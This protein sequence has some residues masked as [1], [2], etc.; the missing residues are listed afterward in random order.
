MKP[1]R[2]NRHSLNLHISTSEY[3]WLKGFSR[4]EGMS[5]ADIIRDQIRASML[6]ELALVAIEARIRCAWAWCYSPPQ[7]AGENV[8]RPELCVGHEALAAKIL[9]ESKKAARE[10]RFRAER[11]FEE[12]VRAEDLARRKRLDLRRGRRAK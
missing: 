11:A 5:M 10:M 4:H 1:S 7:G 6:R 9:E 3:A 12:K 8:E 2:E